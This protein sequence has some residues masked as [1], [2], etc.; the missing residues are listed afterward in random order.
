MATTENEVR[1]KVLK[2]IKPGDQ[3]QPLL[4]KQE[5]ILPTLTDALEFIYQATNHTKF[6]MDAREGFVYA[7]D[8]ETVTVPPPPAPKTWSL[9]GDE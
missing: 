6:Y 7:V 4:T 8:L 5:V 2:R 9:Y 3:W 1:T